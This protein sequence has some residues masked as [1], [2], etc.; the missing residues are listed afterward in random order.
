[1]KIGLVIDAFYPYVDGVVVVVDNYAR[2]LSKYHEVVVFAP[3]P[4]RYDDSKLPY[5]V[6]R[7]TSVNIDNF[8]YSIALPIFD[9]NI[10]HLLKEQNL[11]IIHVHSPFFLGQHAIH[12]GEKHHIPT[13]CTIHTQFIDEFKRF[14]NN[15]DISELINKYCCIKTFDKCDEC[16]TL[17]SGMKDLYEKMGLQN[18]LTII[19]NATDLKLI[20]DDK[21]LDF[22]N[23][24]Y[25]LEKDTILF[26]FIGRLISVKN[27]FFLA[28]AFKLINQKYP[29]TKLM[30][31]GG[32]EEEKELEQLIKELQLEDKVILAGKIFDRRLLSLIY[33]RSKLFLFPSLFDAN[34]L[35]QIEAASQKT[36]TVFI[37]HAIT[38][39]NIIDNE[40][41][42]LAPNDVQLFAQRVI[43][44]IENQEL[45]EK[46][47]NN[48][49][50]T[51]YK[52]WDDIALYV[53]K[54]YQTL[55]DNKGENN[56]I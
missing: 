48:A 47:S 23:K 52:T 38:A 7:V 34:S 3:K 56:E 49:Y 24:E 20:E 21:Q 13:V 12:F 35:V 19:P 40:N 28:K 15:D 44:I 8:D 31:V 22:I 45:Y 55:I 32:G 5:K 14:T 39:S 53:I 25:Q 1:M 10:N 50:Q 42:F 41:G 18:P 43:Q 9:M 51:I 33:R 4:K 27:I 6:I 26:S 54:K 36:P 11:D 30:Y 29:D 17:N 2:S 37:N 16:W 46:V